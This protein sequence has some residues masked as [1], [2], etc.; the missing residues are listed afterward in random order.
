[1]KGLALVIGPK[2]AAPPKE[3]G[4]SGPEGPAEEETEASEEGGSE[5]E[6]ATLAAE[7]IAGGDTEAAADAMVSM[8]KACLRNY[9]GKG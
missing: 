6:Y 2:K 8:V 1:M 3:S 9:G 7:A 5:K 4:Y